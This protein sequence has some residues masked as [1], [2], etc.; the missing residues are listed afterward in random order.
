[1][2]GFRTTVL[3]LSSFTRRLF[4]PAVFII[5]MIGLCKTSSFLHIKRKLFWKQLMHLLSKNNLDNI[6]YYDELSP[7]FCRFYSL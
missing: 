7:D 4:E 5:I 1:M 2:T 3:M 6:I